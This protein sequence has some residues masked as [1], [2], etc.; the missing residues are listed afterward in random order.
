MQ[1]Q[2]HTTNTNQEEC[3]SEKIKNKIRNKSR[4][5]HV[6][7]IKEENVITFNKAI[8]QIVKEYQAKGKKIHFVD[9]F[10]PINKTYEKSMN[11]DNLHPNAVGNKLMAEQWFKAIKKEVR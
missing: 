6:E 2:T 10:T 7:K 5:L 1:Q 11:G 8:P 9:I 3:V 4:R